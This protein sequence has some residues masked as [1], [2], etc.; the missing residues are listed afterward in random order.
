MNHLDIHTV[1]NPKGEQIYRTLAQN[2]MNGQ[3]LPGERLKIRQLAEQMGTSVTPVRDALLWLVQDG[4]LVMRTPRDI[5]VRNL[6]L[7]EY[8]EIRNI[9]LQLEGMA[10]AEAALRASQ[11]D[12]AKLARILAD[13]EQAIARQDHAR[14]IML[15]QHFHFELCRIARMPILTATLNRLWMKIGPLIAQSYPHGGRD[16]VIHHYPVLDALRTG[17]HL[18][19]RIAIQTDLLHG[20]QIILQRKTAETTA[21]ADRRPRRSRP[22]TA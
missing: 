19:A 13:N 21:T 14:G 3:L 8:L 20:G 16:M 7:D 12:L 9:R 6:T 22:E 2:L 17:D 5:R 18:A 10:A 15:N 11:A 1:S 4:A